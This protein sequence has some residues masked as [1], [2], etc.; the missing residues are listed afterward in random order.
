M[1]IVY[2]VIALLGSIAFSMIGMCPWLE[3][4]WK[5]AGFIASAVWAFACIGL[6]MYYS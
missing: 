2:L 1:M 3:P 4:H 6:G 5:K